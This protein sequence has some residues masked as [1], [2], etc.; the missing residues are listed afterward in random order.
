[1]RKV[2]RG[3]AAAPGGVWNRSSQLTG[4]CVR[5]P[6]QVP[7]INWF[8]GLP[9]VQGVVA[10]AAPSV[11]P[12]LFGQAGRQFFLLDERDDIEAEPLIVS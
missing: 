7:F 5:L 1:M 6:C 3:G 9:R 2:L 12:W 4:M 8:G 10:A 11:T